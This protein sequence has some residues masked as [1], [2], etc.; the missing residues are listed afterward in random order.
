MLLAV[1]L[2]LVFGSGSGFVLGFDCDVIVTYLGGS[3]WDFDAVL[4]HGGA[5]HRC[6][7]VA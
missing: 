1:V 3:S 7:G 5:C 4:Q 2:V 6:A